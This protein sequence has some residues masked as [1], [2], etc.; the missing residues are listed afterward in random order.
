MTKEKL[1]ELTKKL[2]GEN[3]DFR[4]LME[5]HI[6]FENKLEEYNKKAYLTP[7]EEL[8]RKKIQKLKLMGKDKMEVILSNYRKEK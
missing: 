7:E 6:E 5:E 3:S 2:M 4:R 8:E 1:E